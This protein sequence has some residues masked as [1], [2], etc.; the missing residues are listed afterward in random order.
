MSRKSLIRPAN[1]PTV[2]RHFVSVRLPLSLP[3]DV[4]PKC[5]VYKVGDIVKILGYGD[6]GIGSP[7]RIDAIYQTDRPDAEIFIDITHANGSKNYFSARL[8]DGVTI[9][10]MQTKRPENL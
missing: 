5:A 4:E 3:A 2:V 7:A 9:K 1:K 10:N 8:F 6:K